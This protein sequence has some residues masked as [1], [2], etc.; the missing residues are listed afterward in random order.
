MNMMNSLLTMEERS[1]LQSL[2][3]NNKALA[4]RIIADLKRDVPVRSEM[5]LSLITLSDKL[6]NEKIDFA[7]EMKMID[8]DE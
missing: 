8:S 1:L 3:C 2:G 6:K 4:L 7:Y 5:F